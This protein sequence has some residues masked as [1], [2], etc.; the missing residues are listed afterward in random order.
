MQKPENVDVSSNTESDLSDIFSLLNNISSEP[1]ESKETTL[2]DSLKPYLNKK[3]QKKL[4]QCEKLISIT[5]TLK[6]LNDLHVFDSF[7]KTPDE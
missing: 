4:A 6:L 3:R 2:L 7:L 1:T 5:D